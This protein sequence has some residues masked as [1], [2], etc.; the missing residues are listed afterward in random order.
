MRSGG[1]ATEAAVHIYVFV[2]VKAKQL[3]L[4]CSFSE[5]SVSSLMSLLAT[6]VSFATQGCSYL[7]VG[8]VNDKIGSVRR[9]LFSATDFLHA[10]ALEWTRYVHVKLIDHTHLRLR[11]FMVNLTSNYS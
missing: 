9:W 5:W 6:M 7:C 11:A 3:L 8:V 4:T 2:C 10:Q 1:I